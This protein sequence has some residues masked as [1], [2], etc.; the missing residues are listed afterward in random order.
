MVREHY[1]HSFHLKENTLKYQIYNLLRIRNKNVELFM[2]GSNCSMSKKND[3]NALWQMKINHM[4]K[5]QTLKIFNLL[6]HEC[7]AT[8]VSILLL[9]HSLFF[10]KVRVSQDL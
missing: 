6:R 10:S 4:A 7:T 8:F 3:L 5:F 2:L 9:D 1:F